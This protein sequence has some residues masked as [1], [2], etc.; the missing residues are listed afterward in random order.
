MFLASG[1]FA[2]ATD[3]AADARAART[4]HY[5]VALAKCD[6]ESSPKQAACRSAAKAATDYSK[7][8]AVVQDPSYPTDSQGRLQFDP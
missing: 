8:V 5:E 2:F 6:A 3:A 7:R 1:Q 4:A